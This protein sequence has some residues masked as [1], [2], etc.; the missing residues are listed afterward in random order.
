MSA[1][2]GCVLRFF[3]GGVGNRLNTILYQL[4]FGFL[5]AG[6]LQFLKE[7]E[8]VSFK[9]ALKAATLSSLYAEREV[10]FVLAER[11]VSGPLSS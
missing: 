4:F 1:L 11:A 5:E 2:V 9:T 7:T 3:P 10:L 8:N 6:N